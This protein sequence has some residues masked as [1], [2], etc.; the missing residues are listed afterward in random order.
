MPFATRLYDLAIRAQLKFTVAG[1]ANERLAIRLQEEEFR[2][3]ALDGLQRHQQ[4]QQGARKVGV[5]QIHALEAQ[6]RPVGQQES[7]VL[8]PGQTRRLALLGK[9][10]VQGNLHGD[11][12]SRSDIGKQS[13]K[14]Y[15][16]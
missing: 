8:P 6:S 11:L 1:N 9:A 13:S 15:A 12:P 14:A 16:G 10:E 7:A 2:V 3:S 4:A 5:R